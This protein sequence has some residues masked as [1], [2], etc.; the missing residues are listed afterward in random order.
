MRYFKFSIMLILV[1]LMAGGVFAQ[2]RNSQWEIFLGGAVPTGP[3]EIKDSF[4]VGGSFH[5]Q[6]VM[7]LTPRLGLSFGLAGEGF[8]VKQEIE[9]AGI[10]GELTVGELGIGLR[11]YLTG[12]DANIQ[13]YLF[14]M[15]TYNVV[16]AT[17]SDDFGNELE[18]KEEKAGIA[19]GGGLE[20]P[21]GARFNLLFQ[22]L[23]RT[24]FTEG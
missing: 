12:L 18:A 7:F 10:D 5:L 21:A 2:Q 20:V 6:Y 1:I 17:F 9:D 4:E 11:P 14:G 19:L 16:K 3:E 24:I 15:G 22:A 8:K 23:G 13:I